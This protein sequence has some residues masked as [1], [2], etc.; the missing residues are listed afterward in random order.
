M[1]QM[2]SPSLL[3]FPNLFLY[4]LPAL[5][6][7]LWF[8]FLPPPCL[9]PFSPTWFCP[10]TIS[11]IF[12]A[13]RLTFPSVSEMSSLLSLVLFP[14]GESSLLCDI[15]SGS[16]CPVVLLGLCQDLFELLHNSSHPG[17]EAPR[18]LLSACF[19]WPGLSKDMGLWAHACLCCQLCKIQT[20]VQAS[21][22]AIPVPPRRF[23]HVHLDLVGPLPSNHG[24]TYLLIMI[25]R[26]T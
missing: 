9:C 21:V 19:V 26:T 3:L 13:L 6:H 4:L 22:P 18:R 1:W 5:Q 17:V 8:L 7:P 11:A 2:L 15:S 10:P 24:F 25:D 20:H 16:L 23:S 12:L 14:F